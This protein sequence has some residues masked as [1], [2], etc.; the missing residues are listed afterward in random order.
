MKGCKRRGE[1]F[2]AGL[3]SILK[4]HARTAIAPRANVGASP[5]ASH[6]THLPILYQQLAKRCTVTSIINLSL[7][8]FIPA[9]NNT[10]DRS[11]PGQH[12]DAASCDARQATVCALPLGSLLGSWLCFALFLTTRC[13]YR[14]NTLHW[15]K[16]SVQTGKQ[17][18]V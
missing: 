5:L 7:S 10:R 6:F 13:P 18:R 3:Q 1:W 14:S 15:H 17:S 9:N 16:G 11:L 2:R 4:V 8:C 12:Q